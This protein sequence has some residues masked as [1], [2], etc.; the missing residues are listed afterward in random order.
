MNRVHIVGRK[1]HGKTQLIFELIE[2]FAR[3]GLRVGSIKHSPHAHELDHPGKDSHRHRRAGAHPSAVVTSDLIDVFQRREGADFY[4]QLG[5][6]FQ[7]CELMLVEGDF[8]GPGLK[9]EVWRQ[10]IG[11]PC[12]ANGRSDISAIISDDQ[13]QM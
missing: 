2:E 13:P 9:V 5:P 8:D 3:R 1:N 10:A 12:L 4:R 11:G 7:D 6:A